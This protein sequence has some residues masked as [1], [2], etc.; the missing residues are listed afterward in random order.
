[1]IG[2]SSSYAALELRTAVSL[3]EISLR[4]LAEGL[5]LRSGRLYR[6]EDDEIK[7]LGRVATGST[8][9]TGVQSTQ[10]G[11]EWISAAR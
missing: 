6:N 4:D 3:F 2:F 11:T 1:V 5:F 9:N 8:R 10:G 7:Q